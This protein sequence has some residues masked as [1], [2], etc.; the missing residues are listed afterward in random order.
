[1]RIGSAAAW[2]A[3]FGGKR[4]PGWICVFLLLFVCC[5]ILPAYRS[6]FAVRLASVFFQ[7]CGISLVVIGVSNALRERG[8]PGLLQAL[9]IYFSQAPWRTVDAHAK[10]DGTEVGVD[11]GRA[12]AHVTNP[13]ADD[14]LEALRARLMEYMRETNRALSEASKRVDSLERSL[15]RS[16]RRL[17]QAQVLDRA[18][19]QHELTEGLVGSYALSV[20]GAVYL[21]VGAVLGTFPAE[22]A[23]LLPAW[24]A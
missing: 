20:V 15:S 18:R 22:I 24:W 13:P 8:K 6:D 14:S 19:L 9:K 16:V 2:K 5:L 7:L 3:W 11:S 17:E 4:A 21:A 23:R 12:Y 1:M 10:L